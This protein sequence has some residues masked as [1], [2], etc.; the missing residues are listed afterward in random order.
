MRV[1]VI[2]VLL[3][4]IMGIEWMAEMDEK[5]NY[6]TAIWQKLLSSQKLIKQWSVYD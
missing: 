2:S 1:S 4:V 5:D 3:L 6:L